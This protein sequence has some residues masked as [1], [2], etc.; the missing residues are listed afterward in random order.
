MHCG[1]KYAL[2][3]FRPFFPKVFICFSIFFFYFFQDYTVLKSDQ[4]EQ[5]IFAE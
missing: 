2:M 4:T 3:A 1:L 5:Q